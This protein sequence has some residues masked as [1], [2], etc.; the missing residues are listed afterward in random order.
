MNCVLVSENITNILLK[1]FSKYIDKWVGFSRLL[2][3][4]TRRQYERPT[5][6]RDPERGSMGKEAGRLQEAF[7]KESADKKIFKGM[8]TEP[9]AGPSYE[10]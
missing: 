7:F 2:G 9:Y 1:T 3:T 10:R 6:L 4:P 8:T 5:A